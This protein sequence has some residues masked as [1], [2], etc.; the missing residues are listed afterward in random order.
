MRVEGTGRAVAATSSVS[1]YPLTITSGPEHV[2]ALAATLA[3]FGKQ[4]RQGISQADELGDADAADADSDAWGQHGNDGGGVS[5]ADGRHGP[6][7]QRRRALP[8]QWGAL[9]SPVGGKE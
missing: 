1:E 8:R 2:A 4:V 3:T 7:L 6:R 5:R 9:R